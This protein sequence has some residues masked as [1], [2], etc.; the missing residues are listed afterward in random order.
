MTPSPLRFIKEHEEFLRKDIVSGAYSGLVILDN[1]NQR[2]MAL[3]ENYDEATFFT[4][5]HAHIAI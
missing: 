3:F 2:L 5:R 4:L 1:V